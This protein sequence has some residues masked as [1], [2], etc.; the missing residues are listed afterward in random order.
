MLQLFVRVV[1]QRAGVY[2]RM[3]LPHGVDRTASVCDRSSKTSWRADSLEFARHILTW[4]TQMDFPERHSFTIQEQIDRL[5]ENGVIF[6]KCS[7]E[8]AAEYLND[9]TYYFKIKAFDKSFVKLPNGKYA[10][11]DFALLR[12]LA[13]VDHRLRMLL[14]EL[15][16]DIEHAVRIR[17]NQILMGSD[18]RG[19]E[20]LANSDYTNKAGHLSNPHE[21]VY[22]KAMV[23]KYKKK[24]PLWVFWEA[25]TMRELFDCYKKFLDSQKLVDPARNLLESVRRLRNAA[26][27][28]NCLLIPRSEPTKPTKDIATYLPVLMG[29]DLGGLTQIRN[30][31]HKD[32][33]VND[34]CCLVIAHSM[35]VLSP[36]ARKRAREGIGK[37]RERMNRNASW[38]TEDCTVAR[39]LTRQRIA[40]N[41][42]L[43]SYE[44][45]AEQ[46]GNDSERYERLLILPHK[47][48]KR[49][50]TRSGK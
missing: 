24:P 17:F 14:F 42:L 12:D 6:E 37:F 43:Q 28:H 50:G 45:F 20:F 46:V 18:D 21:S 47:P 33:L 19:Y 8:D 11:L 2:G 25:S 1:R 4:R 49:R 3:A 35:L 16:A 23:N 39:S 32:T 40:L 29:D 41:A 13:S 9:C 38:Y 48:R 15:T 22:N 27:H 30:T 5:V 10:N 31:Y 7:L 26:A 44:R 34:L 36:R